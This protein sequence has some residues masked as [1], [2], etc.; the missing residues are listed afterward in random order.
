[1]NSAK[2]ASYDVHGVIRIQTN[3]VG[4][5][6]PEYFRVPTTTPNLEIRLVETLSHDN[7]AG[8]RRR[9]GYGSYE[10]GPHEMMYECDIPFMYLLGSGLRWST[11]VRGL[12]Q[13]ETSIETSIP[14]FRAAP[15]RAKATQF[16]ARMVRIVQGLKLATKGL[17]PCY[18]TAVSHEDDASLLLGYSWSGKSTIASLLLDDGFSY[19]SDDYSILDPEGNVHCYPDWHQPRTAAKQVPFLRYFRRTPLDSRTGGI[20]EPP[21]RPRAR[22][23]RLIFLER[24][25]DGV[26]ELDVDEA[27]R[28]IWLINQEEVDKNWSSPLSQMVS[29]YAYLNPGLD[30]RTI[31]GRYGACIESAV[32]RAEARTLVRSESPRFEAVRNLL[33]RDSAG[34]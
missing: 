26:E 4:L 28:R 1:M 8:A 23:R 34:R 21:V 16:L 20:Q 30:L 18:A 6:I 29:Y 31:L 25:S 33:S 2:V 3:M 32:R 9:V 22:V 10:L 17:A 15:V 7:R 5:E 24:G 27:L 12:D 19:L 13:E 14:F 11:Y